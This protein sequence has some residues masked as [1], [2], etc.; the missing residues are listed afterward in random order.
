MKRTAYTL[1]ELIFIVVIIGILS[2]VAFY[3]FKPNY[4]KDDAAKVLMQL[5]ATRYQAIGYDKALN[6]LG[7]PDYLTG[8]IDLT[9]MDKDSTALNGSTDYKFHSTI[10]AKTTSGTS[11]DTLCYDKFGR[12]Y[13]GTQDNNATDIEQSL[14]NNDINIT[15]F[16]PTPND[17]VA[18]LI[19]HK[20]G[21]PRIFYTD[22][23]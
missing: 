19:D 9:Q 13:D 2:G 23:L 22:L 4:L 11:V 18:I 20:T 7:S 21:F 8:C 14:I 1:L 17:S 6:N 3:S 5:E 10:T 15:L 12:I 16:Y